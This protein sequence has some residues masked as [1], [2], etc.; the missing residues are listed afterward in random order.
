[1]KDIRTGAKAHLPAGLSL[2]LA[3]SLAFFMCFTVCTEVVLYRYMVVLAFVILL[4][5]AVRSRLV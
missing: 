2:L 4:F 3:I 1:M 5:V